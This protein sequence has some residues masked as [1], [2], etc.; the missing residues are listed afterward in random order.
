VVLLDD[1]ATPFGD[2]QTESVVSGVVVLEKSAPAYGRTRRLTVNKVRGTDFRDGYH[3][4]ELKR[5]GMMVYPRLVAADFHSGEHPQPLPS[6]I[7]GL[8]AML[9]GGLEAGTVTVLIGPSGVGKSTIAMQYV[10][11]ALMEGHRA[12]VYTF[13]EVLDTLFHR[14]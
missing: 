10:A 1:H 12:A 5:G 6:H 4:Y 11:T 3:D 8:D 14:S 7:P 13:D 9:K 2:V